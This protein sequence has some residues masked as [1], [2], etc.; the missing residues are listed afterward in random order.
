LGVEVVTAKYL[1]LHTGDDLNAN[2]LLKIKNGG[3][4]VIERAEMIEMG[5]P[6]DLVRDQYLVFGVTAE[7]ESELIGK[8]WNLSRLSRFNPGS[9]KGVPFTATLKEL[10][11]ELKSS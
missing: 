1:L 9:K 10:F 3:P 4:K 7:I 5:Y 11:Q 2:I 8:H 6:S